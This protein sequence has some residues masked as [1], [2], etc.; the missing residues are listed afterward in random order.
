[1]ISKAQTRRIGGNNLLNHQPRLTSMEKG[2]LRWAMAEPGDKVLDVSVSSGLMLEYLQ[3]RMDCEVCGMSDDMECVRAARSRLQ[4]ADV[5]YAG[6]GEIPW[7]DASFDSVFLRPASLS[8]GERDRVLCEAMR[9]LRPGGQLLAGVYWL[10][11]PVRRLMDRWDEDDAPRAA[12]AHNRAELLA[13]LSAH[14]FTQVTWQ[15]VDLT[16]GVAIGWKPET[17]ENE[18]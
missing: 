9:V 14:S 8:G 2:L 13:D 6:L 5:V 12:R 11:E 7:R 15:T 1:M 18:L 10:P 3:R 16:H 4:N 17:N